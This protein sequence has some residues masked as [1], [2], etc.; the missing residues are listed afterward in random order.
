MN[1]RPVEPLRWWPATVILSGAAVA[2]MA[3]WIPD[4]P[5]RQTVVFGSLG[6]LAI[7]VLLLLIW[8]FAFSR[9][10][11]RQRTS[12]AIGLL[13]VG[14][15]L[16]ATVRIRGSAA[17]SSPSFPGAGGGDWRGRRGKSPRCP[18]RSN[19]RLPAVPRTIEECFPPRPG[20]E[21]LVQSAPAR[22]LAPTRRPGM[23]VLRYRR[24]TRHY[25]GQRGDQECVVSYDLLTGKE[26]WVSMDTARF[27]STVAGVGPRAT[28]T[29]HGG[30]VFSYGALGHLNCL[31]LETGRK[32]WSRHP[33]S[34]N[35]SRPNMWGNSCSPLIDA[36]AVIVS[37]GGEDNNALVAYEAAT[38]EV[39][40]RGGNSRLGY[41]SPT[42]VH[43]SGKKQILIFNAG[44]LASHNAENGHPLWTQPWPVS[45]SAPRSRSSCPVIACFSRVGTDR[46]QAVPDQPIRA[47]TECVDTLGVTTLEDEIHECGRP[48][49]IH[50][51][52]GRRRC[53]SVSTRNGNADGNAA[54]TGTVRSSSWETTSSC[55]PSR[56]SWP[57]L[58]PIRR[59]TGSLRVTRLS[60]PKRGTIR[61]SRP[62]TFSY[63]TTA[64]PSAL[65][66]DWKTRRVSRQPGRASPRVRAVGNSRFGSGFRLQC[67]YEI[68]A[69]RYA[70]GRPT[71][72]QTDSQDE[73]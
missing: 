54:V 21:R 41:S 48:R 47:G 46:K 1:Q 43:L 67:R 10:P 17:I 59:D 69:K 25:A 22:G 2:L 68:R 26:R 12:M 8:F 23:V 14:I 5:N 37:A 62:P 58:R 49:R 55:R 44:Q 16:V 4:M 30:R 71:R 39:P 51:R 29:I 28:P 57:W 52:I 27:E 36:G 15:T 72:D 7:S 42:V 56:A 31:D 11:G 13:L 45:R 38:G 33:I 20:S 53:S 34:E 66:L 61:P 9:L 24:N 6:T 64:K 35:Y 3:L 40:R 50:L 65:I 32:I 19:R 60:T 70:G 63:A 73:A 18:P